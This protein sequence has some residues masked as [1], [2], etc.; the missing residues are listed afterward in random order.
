MHWEPSYSRTDRKFPVRLRCP[1]CRKQPFNGS[2]SE[3]IFAESLYEVKGGELIVFAHNSDLYPAGTC[4]A[5]CVCG[6]RWKPRGKRTI[7][8]FEV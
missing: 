2:I 4:E 3:H 6:Y 1:S 8:S 5:H 7:L